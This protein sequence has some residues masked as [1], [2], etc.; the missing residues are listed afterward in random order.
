MV[1]TIEET[2]SQLAPTLSNPTQLEDVFMID[3]AARALAAALIRKRVR[4]S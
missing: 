4:A 2:V 1:E 3:Q